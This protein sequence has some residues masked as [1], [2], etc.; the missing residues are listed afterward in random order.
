VKHVIL[1]QRPVQQRKTP[2]AFTLIELLVVIAIIAIL[3]GLLLPALASAKEAARRTMCLNNNKQLGLS[4]Q[5]YVDDNEQQFYPRTLK[6]GCWMTGLRE[7]YQ[8]L[9]LL[10]CPTDDPAPKGYGGGTTDADLARR[11]YLLNAWNDYFKTVLS[12]GQFA[13][14]MKGTNLT[15]MPESNVRHPSETILFGEK[16]SGSGHV[17]MD[18]V[19][20]DG[21]DI[22][23]I[24]MGR[25]SNAGRPGQGGGSNYGF[26]DGS[27]RYLKYGYSVSPINL[28]AVQEDW[29]TNVVYG[30]P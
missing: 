29:R 16:E 9:R 3:A 28:W 12:D 10:W 8:N 6:P 22:L 20:G 4:H 15:C 11:S 21:N 18:F 13:D 25:H 26:A 27:A 14:Y 7:D 19:Q 5:L 2:L 17:Y 30:M 24:E 1:A 23:E